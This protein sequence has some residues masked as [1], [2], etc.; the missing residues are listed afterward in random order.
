MSKRTAMLRDLDALI[1]Q[2]VPYALDWYNPCE[3]IL[4][5]N[6]FGMPSYGLPRYGEYEAAF[7]Y[8]WYD[9]AKAERLK[10]TLQNGQSMGAIPELQI[11]PWQDNAASN[12][13]V[14]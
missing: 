9:P 5:W 2:Q 3:R 4:Y 7:T 13:A 1:Y 12:Q 14:N 10:T 6:K 8:W 11:R